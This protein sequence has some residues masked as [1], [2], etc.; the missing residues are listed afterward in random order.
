MLNK[1]RIFQII[2]IGDKTDFWSRLFDM[3][4][5]III[6][7]INIIVLFLQ[8]FNELEAYYSLFNI[9]ESRMLVV[10]ISL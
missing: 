4:I 6:I 2:Q 5:S 1:K 3:F 10:L 7:I 8:T 9:I